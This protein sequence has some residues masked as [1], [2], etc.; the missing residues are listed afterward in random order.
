MNVAL[1]IE[2]SRNAQRQA[3]A[4]GV[5]VGEIVDAV[6]TGPWRVGRT[7]WR[8]SR[9][10]YPCLRLYGEGRLA[11]ME[12]LGASARVAALPAP[13]VRIAIL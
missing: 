7:G 8:E 12:I 4:R 13:E 1:P 6:R 11:G 10:N 3:D 5:S 2:L 9:K